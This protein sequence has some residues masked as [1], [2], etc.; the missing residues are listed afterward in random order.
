[1][2]ALVENAGNLLNDR[3]QA[4]ATFFATV[5]VIAD[6]VILAVETLKVAIGK[7]HIADTLGTTYRWLFPMMNAY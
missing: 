7:K 2:N 1:M 5:P 3:L 4:L 6:L